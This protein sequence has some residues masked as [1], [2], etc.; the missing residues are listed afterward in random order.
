MKKHSVRSALAAGLVASLAAALAITIASP[1]SAA[2]LITDNEIA[3]GTYTLTLSPE[4]RSGESGGTAAVKYAPAQIDISTGCPEGFRRSSR[5]FMVSPTGVETEIA[6][7][8]T[9]MNA[10]AWGLQ[11]NAIK[12]TGNR[13]ADFT[14]LDETT[15]PTGINAL[16]ITCDAPN[17]DGGFIPNGQP[18]GTSKYF[19]TYLE[20][21]RTADS[22]KVVPAPTTPVEKTATTTTLAA[23]GTTETSTTITATVAPAAASGTVTFRQGGTQIG[24]PVTVTNGAATY[25]VSG[26]TGATD[27]SFTATYSGDAT[28]EASTSTAVAV[29]TLPAVPPVDTAT[30]D[31]TVNVPT[32]EDS[33]P[34]GL[35]ISTKPGAVTLAGGVRA[36]NQVW[37][38]KGP[39]GDVTV[40]DDR[41][42]ATKSAWT[43][44]GSSSEFVSGSDKIAPSALSWTPMKVSGAG[45]AGGA[46]QSLATSQTLASGAASAD[47]NVTT[48]VNAELELKVP[49]TAPAGSYK[50]TLTLTLI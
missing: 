37:S 31:V 38:A 47:K 45:E 32:L 48:T 15:F 41:R 23:S 8:R 36:D 40:K 26:L 44:G 19:V 7:A 12:L 46:A 6:I 49:A 34:T 39:L 11:G 24:Q 29:T 16:V 21:D 1:A 25:S 4:A 18:I 50:A 20:V 43:L 14:N 28:H 22:W 35:A 17:A 5:T 13:A 2:E 33:G 9:N 42:D 3:G 30:P 27:Y 10:A